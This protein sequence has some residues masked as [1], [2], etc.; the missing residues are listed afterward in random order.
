MASQ[1]LTVV[2]SNN[3]HPKDLS[4]E[5]LET[6][7][8]ISLGQAC[9]FCAQRLHYDPRHSCDTC[10]SI[11]CLS[12]EYKCVYYRD[13]KCIKCGDY[14][15]GRTFDFETGKTIFSNDICYVK[16]ESGIVTKSASH[17]S[18]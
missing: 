10:R 18:K 1:K 12:C 17:N 3:T 8:L 15:S 13:R 9:I 11:Y 2:V 4:N 6:L 14:I 16:T 7:Q 5:T